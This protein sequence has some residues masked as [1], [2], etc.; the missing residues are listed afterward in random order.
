MSKSFLQIDTNPRLTRINPRDLITPMAGPAP[1]G[2]PVHFPVTGFVEVDDHEKDRIGI[3][4]L[5]LFNYSIQA[6][7][8]DH[9]EREEGW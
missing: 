5:I 9:D 6:S 4:D 1:V 3:C 7:Q 8:F 2:Q